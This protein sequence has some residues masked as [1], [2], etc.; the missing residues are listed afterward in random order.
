L[1]PEISKQSLGVNKTVCVFSYI[2][3]RPASVKNN[4]KEILDVV[5][6]EK[7]GVVKEVPRSYFSHIN[8]RFLH[9]P[10]SKKQT[11]RSHAQENSIRLPSLPDTQE[12]NLTNKPLM[13]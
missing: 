12:K 9:W 7:K 5:H 13:C 4:E 3:S 1:T 6:L 8:R 10:P 11:K 2:G